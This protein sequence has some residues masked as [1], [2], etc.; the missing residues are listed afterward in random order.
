MQS[1]SHLAGVYAAAVTPLN[2]QFELLP[3][4]LLSLLSFLAGR[5]CH[6]ALLFGTTGE[7]PS[8]SAAERRLILQAACA[9][10]ENYPDF[11]LLAGTGSPSLDDS[12]RLT[13][14]AF[15]LGYEAVV[16]L[17][18]FFYRKASEEGLFSWYSELIRKSV[19][20]GAAL[21]AYHIPQVSGISIS[22]N[23]LERLKGAF[24]DQFAGL[25]D[26]SADPKHARLLGEHFGDDLLIL[27]GT[28]S[29]FS[30]ALENS[31]SG[32]ITA[33][34]NLFSPLNRQIWTAWRSGKT[35]PEVQDRLN[36]VRAVLDRYQPAPPLVKCVLHHWYSLPLWTV[37]YP[38]LPLAPETEQAVLEALNSAVAPAK[39]V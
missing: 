33:L 12:I 21:L 39:T 24:P 18:P 13:R 25:K 37:R 23:L 32:C 6:G 38:L 17:P 5:G 34:A 20:P 11:R 2:D 4:D 9:V 27:N 10:R 16:V 36:L 28:D 31:A 7:G 35:V 30:L 19:P 14:L 22:I 29:L 3:D 1:F 8:F 15:D 26:S